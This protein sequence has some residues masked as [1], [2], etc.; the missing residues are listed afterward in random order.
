MQ[1]HDRLMEQQIQL[2]MSQ[3]NI[4]TV[5]ALAQA[6]DAGKANLK[7]NDLE[8]VE[9]VLDD[10]ADQNTQMSQIQDSLAMP[11]GMMADL[12]GD[13]LDDELAV[14]CLPFLCAAGGLT[15]LQ[16]VRQRR[17][18]RGCVC[19]TV[20]L[21]GDDLGDERL[22]CFVCCVRCV[23]CVLQQ[24]GSGRRRP[25][26]C[27]VSRFVVVVFHV[28]QTNTQTSSCARPTKRRVGRRNVAVCRRWS[29]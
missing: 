7:A 23:G 11:T 2:D 4:M 1:N 6:A 22:P 10:I 26:R 25:L 21:D 17:G 19:S 9:E 29:R 27:A 20:D 14:R 24:L 5:Q 3:S 16:K 18:V 8:N 28:L 12:D 15:L 13:D